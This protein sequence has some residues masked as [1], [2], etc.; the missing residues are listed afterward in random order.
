MLARDEISDWTPKAFV[1]SDDRWKL[2]Q[3][4]NR[5]NG[6]RISAMDIQ[7]AVTNWK[8]GAATTADQT[9]GTAEKIRRMI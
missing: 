4:L 3:V 6:F 9:T 8:N 1:D 2:H 5:G 7:I